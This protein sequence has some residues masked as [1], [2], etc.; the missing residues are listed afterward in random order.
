MDLGLSGLASGFDWRA[1]I[2][3][4][5]EVERA[6]Q[7]RLRTEQTLLE[8]R[9][10]AYGGLVTQLNVLKGRVE[11]LNSPTLFESR[12]TAVGDAEVA[13]AT[14]Q[15]GTANG[16]YTFNI[17]QLASAS[18]QLGSGNIGSPLSATDDVSG[19]VLSS[20]AFASA[21][22]AGTITVNGQ[23]VAIEEGDSLQD[24]FD[25]I[26]TA[27]GVAGTYDSGTDTISLNHGSAIVLGSAND[28]SNF[29]Q[30]A[31]LYNNGTGTITSTAS[32]GAVQIN[33]TLGSAN[34]TTAIS[35]GGS[36]AGEFKVN[37]VSISFDVATDTVADIMARIS[38]S[39]AGVNATYDTVNDRLVLNNKVTGDIGVAL[40]DVTGNFLAATGLSGGTLDRGKNLLYTLD[41]GGQLVST[42]NVITA[43]SSGLTGL[44]VT[45]LSTGST[46]VE[47]K[48]DTEAIKSAIT[49]FIEEYN[50]TQ[51]MIADETSSSTDEDGV[52]TAGVLAGQSTADQLA[53]DLRRQANAVISGLDGT[54]SQL[55][56]LGIHSNGN[57]DTIALTDS[58][59]L[60]AALAGNLQGVK[61]LFADETNGLAVQLEDF[62]ERT[63]GDEGTLI[64]VQDNLT[65]QITDIDDQVATLERLVL[66]NEERLIQ[67][68]VAMEQA[69][70]RINQQM[71][72][73]AQRLGLSQ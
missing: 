60:D 12:S 69:Q 10:V 26:Q 57:D 27:T 40:E 14:A 22:T 41:G 21:A 44:T 51:T 66:A 59:A 4:L 39:E 31:K 43:A 71:S 68:F 24:V 48:S 73:L 53:T 64:T 9:N 47:V 32:L 54:L 49:D 18:R 34:F 11:A 42:S 72:F 70:A 52:V 1:L 38:N 33:N 6:P 67:S 2:E 13:T 37:G 25:K 28:T 61:E 23:Q 46:T 16:S 50:R 55:A 15:S 56:A 3:Q 45:A 5:S 63:A 20:A 65:K 8:Q 19:L 62:L 7:R 17:T 30:V 29:F 58:E 36:G 35:D